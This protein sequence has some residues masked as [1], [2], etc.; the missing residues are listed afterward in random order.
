M[1]MTNGLGTW[2]RVS[3]VCSSLVAAS[4][5]SAEE[6]G[7]TAESRS[8]W[9]RQKCAVFTAAFDDLTAQLGT[10]GASDAFLMGNRSYIASGCLADVD[11][12]PETEKDFAIA[13]GLTIATMNAGAA[14]TFSPFRCR[15]SD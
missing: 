1:M 14:S 12:C 5:A 9:Q 3:L 10:D 6:A 7:T 2:I 13:N 11:A 8:D 15:M 4:A